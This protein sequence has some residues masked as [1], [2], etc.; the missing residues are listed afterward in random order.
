MLSEL[1]KAGPEQ[2]VI[3]WLDSHPAAG[4][5]T[6]PITAA[7]PW[8]SVRRLPG[9]RR[10]TASVTGIDAVLYED[11]QGRIE[12]FDTA[13]ASRGA[14]PATRHVKDFADTGVEVVDPW[15]C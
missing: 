1:V 5:A 15:A 2:R 11:L 6:T 12:R 10:K 14:T 3:D 7:E 9:R 4:L 8:Y 13:A